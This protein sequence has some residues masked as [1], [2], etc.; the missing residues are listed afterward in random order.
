MEFLET[1]KEDIQAFIQALVDFVKTIIDKL[2][3]CGNE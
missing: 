2:N 3:L 1:Y